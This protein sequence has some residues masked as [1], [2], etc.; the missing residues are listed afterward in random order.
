MRWKGFPP[1]SPP[2]KSKKS[3]NKQPKGDKKSEKY[4][5][6]KTKQ[7][8]KNARKPGPKH[9]QCHVSLERYHKTVDGMRKF[10]MPSNAPSPLVYPAPPPSFTRFLMTGK[11]IKT[12]ALPHPSAARVLINSQRQIAAS[13]NHLDHIPPPPPLL[14]PKT[15]LHT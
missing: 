13:E 1:P 11:H 7:K 3:Y 15:R 6:R 12:I 10:R 14:P 4:N 5:K 2:L 9:H 8:K